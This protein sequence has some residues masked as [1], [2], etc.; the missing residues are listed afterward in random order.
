MRGL[1]LFGAGKSKLPY[2]GAGLGALVGLLLLVYT[3]KHT[4]SSHFL[5]GRALLFGHPVK[6]LTRV[7][8]GAAAGAVAGAAVGAGVKAAV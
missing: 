1:D 8:L 2:V 4:R 3:G 7:G 6:R 5:G